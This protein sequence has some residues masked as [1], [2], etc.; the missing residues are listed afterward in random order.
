MSKV[1]VQCFSLVSNRLRENQ[2]RD[3]TRL[4]GNKCKGPLLSEEAVMRQKQMI[5]AV[6]KEIKVT[7]DLEHRHM[8]EGTL[9]IQLLQMII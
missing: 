6:W 5:S 4:W 3:C 7:T 2:G 1:F 8:P 9:K